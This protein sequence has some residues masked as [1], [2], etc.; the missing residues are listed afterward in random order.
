M[1]KKIVKKRDSSLLSPPTI[2]MTLLLALSWVLYGL[3][4]RDPYVVIPNALG[5]ILGLLQSLVYLR[6][7]SPIR[8]SGASAKGHAE[9]PPSE[10]SPT[11]Q[12]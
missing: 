7:R 4:L 6:Y 3:T 8:S 2:L 1:Q 5:G 9:Q 12:S 11:L 10:L